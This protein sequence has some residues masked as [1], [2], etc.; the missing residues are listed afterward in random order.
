MPR[1]SKFK[2][3][4]SRV[5]KGLKE[6]ITQK[7]TTDT[8]V[9]LSRKEVK[10]RE[11]LIKASQKQFSEKAKNNKSPFKTED[12]TITE[13][14]AF[15]HY[16]NTRHRARQSGVPTTKIPKSVKNTEDLKKFNDKLENMI[17]KTTTMEKTKIYRENLKTAMGKVFSSDEYEVLNDMLDNVSD[18]RLKRSLLEYGALD[19]DYVYTPE[20]RRRKFH[21]IYNTFHELSL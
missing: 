5:T 11:K 7:V 20:D 10:R 3:F 4:F 6:I 21:N 16:M 13:E 15:E 1:R 17:R 12:L 2:N 9:E 19:I 18:D 14:S 8:G